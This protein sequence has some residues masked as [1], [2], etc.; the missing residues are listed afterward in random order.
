MLLP[1]ILNEW[2]P[3]NHFSNLISDVVDHIDISAMTKVYEEELRDYREREVLSDTTSEE[4]SKCVN[5]QRNC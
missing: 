2:L 4:D 1:P 3:D 5:L